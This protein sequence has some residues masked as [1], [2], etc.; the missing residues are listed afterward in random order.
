MPRCVDESATPFVLLAILGG[1]VLGGVVL[2]GV[3]EILWQ[4]SKGVRVKLGMK[5]SKLA[6]K[7]VVGG[8]GSRH[9]N[10]RQIVIIDILNSWRD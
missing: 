1:V 3:A 2:G 8:I 7:G 10:D 4:L 9:C 6:F 5:C